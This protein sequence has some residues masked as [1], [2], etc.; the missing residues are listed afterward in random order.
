MNN[1]CKFQVIGNNNN[2]LK[3]N[4]KKQTNNFFRLY[5]IN[6]INLCNE[7]AINYFNLLSQLND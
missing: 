4:S 7:L 5:Q 6:I 3:K 2:R 1:Y